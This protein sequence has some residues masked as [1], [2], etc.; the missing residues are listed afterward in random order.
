MQVPEWLEEPLLH[1]VHHSTMTLEGLL[2]KALAKFDARYVVGEE[3]AARDENKERP[4]VIRAITSAKSQDG[5][6]ALCIL[7]ILI[8]RITL[9]T[10]HWPRLLDGQHCGLLRLFNAGHLR[11]GLALG[12]MDE[13]WLLHADAIGAGI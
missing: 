2:D 13:G 8:M 12:L 9:R 1:L 5:V 3:L 4:C 6:Q 7:T 11:L 10:Q